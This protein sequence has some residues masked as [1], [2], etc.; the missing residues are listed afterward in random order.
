MDI[1]SSDMYWYER[2]VRSRPVV[3]FQTANAGRAQALFSALSAMAGNAPGR[4]ILK[5]L[6]STGFREPNLSAYAAVE[7]AY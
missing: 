3:T 1:I 6:T 7:K 4:E 5:D 2:S